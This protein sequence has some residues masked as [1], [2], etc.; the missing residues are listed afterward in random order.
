MLG[1]RRRAPRRDRAPAA[2][3]CS[4]PA[5]GARSLS[6]ALR[7]QMTVLSILVNTQT[8][9]L[10]VGAVATPA[11]LGQLGIGSQVAEAGRLRRRRRAVAADLAPLGAPRRA[12]AGRAGGAVR[13]AAPAVAA[14][15]SRRHRRRRRG[16][17]TR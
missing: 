17:C 16:R 7:L 13:A 4:P 11:T 1:A 2:R 14:R 5:S 10:V 8:D 12:R 9:K 6:F 3:A 15:R